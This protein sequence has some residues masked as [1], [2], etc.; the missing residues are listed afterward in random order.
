MDPGSREKQYEG[1]ARK[2]YNVPGQASELSREIYCK[3]RRNTALPET[4]YANQGIGRGGGGN[5]SKKHLLL[6]H[7]AGKGDCLRCETPES[8][9]IDLNFVLRALLWG[10]KCLAKIRKG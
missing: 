8:T 1:L 6:A 5:Y 2:L 4:S 9:A 10:F 7:V 3:G